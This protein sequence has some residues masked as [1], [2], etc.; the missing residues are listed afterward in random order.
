MSVRMMDRLRPL[1]RLGLAAALEGLLVLASA[2]DAQAV[3]IKDIARVDGVRANQL[4]GYG[5]VVGLDR[6]G[7]SQRVQFTL[8]SLTAMLSRMGVRIDPNDLVL[9]NVAAVMV[10]ASLPPFAA[11]GTP[12]DVSVSSIGDARSLAGGT[13]LLTPLLGV[14]GKTY[15]MAQGAVQ[16]GGFG[17]AGLSGSRKQ[18]GHLNAGRVPS[19]GTVERAVPI[20]LADGG[21]LVLNLDR[22]DFTTARQLAAALNDAK[23]RLGVTGDEALAKA[24]SSGT[25]EVTV[26]PDRLE[27]IA[28]FVA[29]LESLD[30]TPSMVARVVIDG[31]TGTIVM[32]ADVRI[33][34]VAVAHGPLNIEV[35]EA[36]E[37]SQPSPLAAGS[38]AA[39]PRSQVD[40][41][42]AADALKL[43]SPGASLASVVDAL[44]ALGAKPRDLVQILMAIKAAGAL[45]GELEVL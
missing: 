28:T 29:D 35:Q 7:D 24:V 37:V 13:L 30:V 10:T 33:S 3:R 31:R 5:L 21:T 36:P 15:G 17:V 42:E 26:P 14:D 43:V 9:R 6:S 34:P 39:V 12:L 18:K 41:E 8:Q 2:A 25:V 19:G 40:A 44:N 23:V 4:V 1:G 45:H 16:V 32:G 22:P 11:A 27:Q 20:L 38:S